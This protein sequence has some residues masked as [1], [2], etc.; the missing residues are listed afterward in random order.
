MFN[1]ALV[2]FRPA[3]M[4]FR[5]NGRFWGDDVPDRET[6]DPKEG[7]FGEIFGA[8]FRCFTYNI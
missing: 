4:R 6:F 3:Y 2:V 7:D 8:F 1:Q 5:L